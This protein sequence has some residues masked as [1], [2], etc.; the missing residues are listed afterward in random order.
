M[1]EIINDIKKMNGE[2]WAAC[3]LAVVFMAACYFS[4]IIF[5]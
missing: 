2:D 1:K 4:I 5:H 3:A